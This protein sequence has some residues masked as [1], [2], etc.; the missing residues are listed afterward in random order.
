MMTIGLNAHLTLICGSSSPR[1]VK[2]IQTLCPCRL[3]P[4]YDVGRGYRHVL[5]IVLP[6]ELWWGLDL[7]HDLYQVLLAEMTRCIW[8][9][10]VDVVFMRDIQNLGLI[11]TC[12]CAIYIPCWL[13]IRVAD[14]HAIVIQ[15]F[16]LPKFRA[17]QNWGNIALLVVYD[18]N[19]AKLHPWLSA[20]RRCGRFVDDLCDRFSLVNLAHL[21]VKQAIVSL[22][23]HF[24]M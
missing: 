13:G 17:C 3:M 1:W 11:L 22:R 10:I 12:I 15:K 19:I 18:P 6:S 24:L 4:Y 16:V 5:L 21:R 20:L 2:T 14:F 23:T 8:A 7:F 9:R